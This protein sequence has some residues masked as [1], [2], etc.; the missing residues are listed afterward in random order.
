MELV[1]GDRALLV[2]LA[3]LADFLL[4]GAE[5]VGF[6]RG[7]GR[8]R[9]G[10][11]DRRLG[12]GRAQLGELLPRVFFRRDGRGGLRWRFRFSRSLFGF[13][14]LDVLQA[15]QLLAGVLRRVER[16]IAGAGGF[17]FS[18]AGGRGIG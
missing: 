12:G 15:R 14:G 13:G 18:F 5:F 8:R 1:A 2:L 4:G 17:T 9:S 7:C 6:G 16:L 10:D 11:F 3:Q